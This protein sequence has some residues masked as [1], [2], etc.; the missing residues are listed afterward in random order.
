V[1]LSYYVTQR[2]SKCANTMNM[3]WD[4]IRLNIT[5]VT[6][7]KLRRDVRKKKAGYPVAVDPLGQN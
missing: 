5:I 1:V 3:E 7:F 6:P 2:C 4:A